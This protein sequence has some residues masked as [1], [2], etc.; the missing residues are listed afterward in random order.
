MIWEHFAYQFDENGILHSLLVARDKADS[1][2]VLH[3]GRARLKFLV[4]TS[5]FSLRSDSVV[6]RYPSRSGCEHR[7]AVLTQ[8]SVI[9]GPQRR[10]GFG[11]RLPLS[12]AKPAS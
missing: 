5:V 12:L 9:I 2:R 6:A 4:V 8:A 7:E 3:A 10:P 1:R 11:P